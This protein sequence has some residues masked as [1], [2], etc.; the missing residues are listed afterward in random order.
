M[1][2]A[3][4]SPPE[5]PRVLVIEDDLQVVQGV[6]SGLR[7]AGFDVSIAMD[8]D[9]GAHRVLSEPFDAVVL[10]LMLPGRDGHAV[11]EAMSGR[12]S[13]PVIVLSAR[14]ELS[15]RLRSFQLGAVDFVPKPFW[16]EELVA[17]LRSRLA[18]RAPE[19]HRILRLG[20]VEID[21]DA[22][23]ASREG[24]DL[25]LTPAELNVLVFLAERPGRAVSRLTLVERALP[26]EGGATERTVDSHVSRL[27]RKLGPEG[28]WLG[29]VW[30]IGYRLD[31]E[32]S[33]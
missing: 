6:A 2:T 27:R 19:A 20:T 8:G 18:L 5:R 22:R 21:L 9:E 10:D 4:H 11:L 28:A 7:R 32:G 29:T 1:S 26:E 12:V 30:G 33:P 3:D 25:G 14:S 31:P 15:A 13:V 17:R 24:E 16:I 23:R